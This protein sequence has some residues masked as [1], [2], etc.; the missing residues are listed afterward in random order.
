MLVAKDWRTDLKLK[1]KSKFTREME[2][3]FEWKLFQE[4]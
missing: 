2:L 4:N 3:E 1:L